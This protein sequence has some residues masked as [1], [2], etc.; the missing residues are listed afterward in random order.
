[1][2]LDND[3][4]FAVGYS[5]PNAGSDAASMRLKAERTEQR[6]Q[7]GLAAQRAE[8]V[9][10]LRALRR[11]VL[12]RHAHRPR[13]Q[14]PRH[15][16]HAR[17]A[18][19]ARHHDPAASGRWATSAPTRCSSRTCSCPTSTWSARSTAASSTS[20]RRSTS[21]ASRCSRSRR[22]SSASTCS[23]TT[24]QRGDRRRRAAA[25]GPGRSQ[26]RSRGWPPTP[27]SPACSACAS[28]PRR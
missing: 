21:S 5:E 18:R 9:D 20:R 3:V 23:A 2:I 6:R 26:P 15:H 28:W 17:A 24:S 22:S 27:R 8:D 16:A 25:R 11:V 19:P 1:M 12:A 13:R 4:E 10:D 7:V 14:A